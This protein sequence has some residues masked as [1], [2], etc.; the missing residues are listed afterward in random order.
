MERFCFPLNYQREVLV[1]LKL[2]ERGSGSL[3]TTMER[4]WYS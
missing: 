1:L 4:F 3:E 2:P